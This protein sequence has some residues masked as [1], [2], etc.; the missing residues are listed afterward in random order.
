MKRIKFFVGPNGCGKT[1]M[2]LN[3]AGDQK[4]L[5]RTTAVIANTPFGHFPQRT[6]TFGLFRVWPRG[7]SGVVAKNIANFFGSDGEENFDISDL[8]K[9]IGFEPKVTL[10]IQLD[11]DD[12]HR[13]DESAYE[14]EELDAIISAFETFGPSGNGRFDLFSSA[15]SLDRSLMKRTG[16]LFKHINKLKKDGVVRSY[17]LLFSHPDR[18]VQKFD[19]LSSGEQTLVSTYLFIKSR[20]PNLGELFIDEPE[21]SLHPEW[22]RQY[23]ETIHMA[24][25]YHDIRVTLASHSPVLVSGALS[26]YG[27]EIEIVRVD[28]NREQPVDVSGA[29]DQE[30]VEKI[31]W[32]AFDTLTPVSHFLSVELSRILQGLADGEIS[33]EMAAVEV[34]DFYSQSYDRKQQ[35]L[36]QGVLDNLSEF[37]THARTD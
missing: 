11:P 34:Q 24:I 32:E 13:L 4:A 36:L 31:L 1:R 28:G 17:T 2:L 19:E 14:I 3:L 18:G 29:K 9:R 30:S 22:Q 6:S 25:G 16:I 10:E 27:E 8:L 23:L 5:P 20:L 33:R 12:E 37:D 26:S 7:I 21:N 15:E 35:N